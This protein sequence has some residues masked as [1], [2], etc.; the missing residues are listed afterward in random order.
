MVRAVLQNQASSWL[1]GAIEITR[2]LGEDVTVS[3]LH[4][5]LTDKKELD[6]MDR[7][8]TA[9]PDKALAANL[10]E[11]LRNTAKTGMQNQDNVITQ[12]R[13]LDNLQFGHVFKPAEEAQTIDLATAIQNSEIIYFQ[14]NVM[15][16]EVSAKAI[17][18]LI[19][20]DLKSLASQ[21]HGE[22][23][24]VKV[25]FLNIFID[26]FGSFAIE[27]FIDFLKMCPDVRFANHLFF[28]S[29][30][31]LDA[32]SPEFKSQ[33][34]QNCLSKLVLRTDDPDEVEFWSGVAGTLDVVDQS[35]QVEQFG[36]FTLRTGAGNSR[37]TKQMKGEHDTFKQLDIGQTVLLQKAPTREDLVQLWLPDVPRITKRAN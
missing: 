21:I 27:G 8:I 24:D 31:D 33:V 36:P 15:A 19:L 17:G 2:A 23:V 18:K 10:S 20:Q 6:R 35:H 4:R 1:G 11:R 28:Q 12:L 34:Q 25:D 32:V 14:L 16:Y 13:D 9:L 22:V 26:E 29:L 37:E 3:G 7:A 30:A 5:L